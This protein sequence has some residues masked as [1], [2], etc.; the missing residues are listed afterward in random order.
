LRD[1]GTG[2]QKRRQSKKNSSHSSLDI[3]VRARTRAGST[4]RNHIARAGSVRR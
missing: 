3:D 1:G 2:K 4:R